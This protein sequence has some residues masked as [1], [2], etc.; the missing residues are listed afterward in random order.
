MTITDDDLYVAA[1]TLASDVSD[2]QLAMGCAYPPLSMIRAVSLKIAVAVAGH[3]NSC[4]KSV[5]LFCSLYYYYIIYST[6]ALKDLKKKLN[7]I[8]NTHHIFYFLFFCIF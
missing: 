2:A 4:G 5:S 3:I 1:V 7:N 6:Q 8:I